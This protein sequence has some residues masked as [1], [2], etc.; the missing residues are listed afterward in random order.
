M[1]IAQVM[2]SKITIPNYQVFYIVKPDSIQMP[3]SYC[4]LPLLERICA[5]SYQCLLPDLYLL[6]ERLDERRPFHRVGF[7]DVVVEQKLDIVYCGQHGDIL[8]S[9]RRQTEF[10]VFPIV[11]HF[12]QCLRW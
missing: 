7:Y 9:V 10:H 1:H 2:E 6:F 5:N 11:F 3:H 8:V 4:K 12:R